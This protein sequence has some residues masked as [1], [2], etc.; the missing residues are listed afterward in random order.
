MPLAYVYGSN[1]LLEADFEEEG[2]A[3][4]VVMTTPAVTNSTE[5]TWVRVYL[6]YDHYFC[7]IAKPNVTHL[8]FEINHPIIMLIINPP[9]LKMICTDIG[10]RYAK[11]ALLRSEMR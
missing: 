10:I 7:L 4:N 9:L 3:D 11:A 6:Q 1:S 8:F 2:W 5:I